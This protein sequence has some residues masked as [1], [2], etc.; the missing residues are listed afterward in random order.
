MLN[1]TILYW[2][3]Q[4]FKWIC[5]RYTCAPHPEP[6][7]YILSKA[8]C[9]LCLLFKKEY[10]FPPYFTSSS[11]IIQISSHYKRAT[12]AISSKLHLKKK[13][14]KILTIGSAN[15]NLTLFETRDNNKFKIKTNQKKPK[16]QKPLQMDKYIVLEEVHLKYTWNKWTFIH[17]QYWPS[18]VSKESACNAGDQ[19]SIP[20]SG[21]S[22]GEENGTPLQYYCLENLMGWGSWWGTVHG[23]TKV[24]HDLVTK[25]PK[26][27]IS[28]WYHKTG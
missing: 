6:S 25:L 27:N 11:K 24:R 21:R 4:I 10:V 12:F 3:C 9:L 7:K 28:N 20:G 16:K 26:P 14:Q 13:C 17:I 15:I 2:F 1:F 8:K 19:G 23:V 18:S 5:H 22:P